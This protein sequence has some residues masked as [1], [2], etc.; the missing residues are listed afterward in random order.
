MAKGH[1]LALPA[2]TRGDCIE[3][4]FCDSCVAVVYTDCFLL[5]VACMML[6]SIITQAHHAVE[7]QA[8]VPTGAISGFNVCIYHHTIHKLMHGL[9]TA[10]ATH[11]PAMQ[12]LLRM[13]QPG[14]RLWVTCSVL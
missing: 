3:P 14:R 7:A 2:S 5:L 11:A 1:L 12:T 6:P 13:H 8:D 10:S 4:A 9:C